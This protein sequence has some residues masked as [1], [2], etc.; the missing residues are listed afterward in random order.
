M[1]QPQSDAIEKVKSEIPPF[2]ELNILLK[3]LIDS[4]RGILK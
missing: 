2:E 1:A 4:K 3:F